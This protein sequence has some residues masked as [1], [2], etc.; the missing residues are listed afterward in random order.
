MQRWISSVIS[1]IVKEHYFGSLH[2]SPL[3]L[4][5]FIHFSLKRVFLLV[6]SQSTLGWTFKI[7][8]KNEIQQQ[9]F[10]VALRIVMLICSSRSVHFGA[11]WHMKDLLLHLLPWIWAKLKIN[12]T[13]IEGKVSL[14]MP[15]WSWALKMA[16]KDRNM[17]PS[18]HP[19]SPEFAFMWVMSNK[20]PQDRRW[21]YK[22][23][24]G[25]L[26]PTRLSLSAWYLWTWKC[27]I[28]LQRM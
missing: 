15:R 16:L 13:K 19:P 3:C 7:Q 10:N 28:L 23:F 26:H 5:T 9:R 17:A 24:S 25:K 27:H 8:H 21:N 1:T 22:R 14:T 11:E 4:Y 6:F 12:L 20:A 2:H 18:I